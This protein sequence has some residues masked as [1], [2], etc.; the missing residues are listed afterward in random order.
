MS[1][2][3]KADSIDVAYRDM[4]EQLSERILVLSGAALVVSDERTTSRYITGG[5]EL[6]AALE[7]RGLP[8]IS[9]L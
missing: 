1:G 3:F 6:N 7:V 4:A 9:G 5:N 2:L 8:R